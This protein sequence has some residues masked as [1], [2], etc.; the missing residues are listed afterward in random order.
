MA[1]LARAGAGG[2]SGSTPQS[3]GTPGQPVPRPSAEYKPLKGGN[4][5]Q[6]SVPADWTTLSSQSAIKAVPPNGYGP[7]NGQTVFSHGVE[8]GVAKAASR[9]L[10][11]ATNAWLKAIAQ[12]NPELRLDGTQQSIRISQRSGLV[13]PLVNPSPLGGQER[14]A[15]YT[16]FLAE[17]SLFYYLTIV[18]ENDATAFR[19][20]FQRIGESI[21][22]TEAR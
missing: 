9:D 5:F 8:F 6:A 14:I 2:E 19:E 4:V 18:Q 17:G 16:T 20:A 10:R 12:S 1:E 21:R 11:Q 3:V 22:L 13:T 7:L 15:V